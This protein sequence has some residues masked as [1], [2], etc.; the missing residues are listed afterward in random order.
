MVSITGVLM[1]QELR[2]LED[3]FSSSFPSSAD[4]SPLEFSSV[5]RKE[6][7]TARRDSVVATSSRPYCRAS[8]LM[9]GSKSPRDCSARLQKASVLSRNT[10]RALTSHFPDLFLLPI[11]LLIVFSELS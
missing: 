8:G 5:Y 2:E 9:T 1:M 3:F 6:S 4:T 10:K 11:N 7:T